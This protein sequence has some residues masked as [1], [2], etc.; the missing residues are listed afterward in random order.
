MSETRNKYNPQPA[1]S[2]EKRAKPAL[3][4]PSGRPQGDGR[5]DPGAIKRNQEHLRVDEDHKTPEMKKHHR[6]TFP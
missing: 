6:G 1:P 5:K 3:Q 4:T 2:T